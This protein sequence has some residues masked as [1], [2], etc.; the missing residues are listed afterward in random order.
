[1]TVLRNQEMQSTK[2]CRY[3]KAYKLVQPPSPERITELLKAARLATIR[4]A[5]Y[6]GE[7]A[8][9]FTEERFDKWEVKSG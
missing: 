5:H 3:R 4:Q 1:M 8:A 6:N 9:D 2:R 7:M